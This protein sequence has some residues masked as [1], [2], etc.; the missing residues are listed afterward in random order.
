M[1][2]YDRRNGG[3]RGGYN[4]R[5][6]RYRGNF[7]SAWFRLE[8]ESTQTTMNMTVGSNVEDTKSLYPSKYG[9]N[10]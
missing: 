9:N 8:A 3:Q 10:C 7:L 1:G 5:K 4:N 6:R 2:D